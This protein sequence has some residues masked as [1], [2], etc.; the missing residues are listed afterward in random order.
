M[1]VTVDDVIYRGLIIRAPGL[2][3]VRLLYTDLGGMSHV[4]IECFG[5]AWS[6][7][8]AGTGPRSVIEFLASCDADYLSNGVS[9]QHTVPAR[10]AAYRRRV[11]EAVIAG[12]KTHLSAR[13]ANAGGD[14]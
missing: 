10:A 5:N 9:P 3:P 1:S 7:F 6:R 14:Q 8:F 4:I 11:C 13:G 2:D 12:A